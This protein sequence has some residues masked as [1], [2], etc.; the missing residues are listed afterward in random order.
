MMSGAVPKMSDFGY[1][2]GSLANIIYGLF[3]NAGSPYSDASGELS[4]YLPEAKKY[5]EPFYNAGANAVPQYQD[6]L[7]GMSNPSGFINNLM[8]GYQESP[9]AKYLQDQSMRAG[10]NAASASGLIGSTPFL[11]QSQQNSAN[12][13]SG[14][15]NQW[16]QNVLGINTQYGSGLGGLIQGGQGSANSLTSL[17]SDYMNSQAGLAYGKGAAEQGQMGG[18]FSGLTGLFGW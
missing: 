6:W 12:I 7:K 4:K 5:Q 10:Q 8:G 15:M 18:L 17:L 2:P 9:Y 14:D 13:A 11:Q 3:G 16:L 1:Q